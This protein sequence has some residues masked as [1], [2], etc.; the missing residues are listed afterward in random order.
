MRFLPRISLSTHSLVVLATGIALVIA[1]LAADLGD[2][3][4]FSAF[5]GGVVLAG[6]GLGATAHQPLSFQQTIDT[7]LVVLL[8][9]LAIVC[10][11]SGGALAAGILLIAAG[12]VLVTESSTRWIR[13]L[14]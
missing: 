8:A 11:A 5:T 10:A 1:A 13:P 9:A 4:T 6:V 7:A 12:T 14:T 3:G 2:I